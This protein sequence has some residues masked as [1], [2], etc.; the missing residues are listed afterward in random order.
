MIGEILLGILALAGSV[1]AY[2]RAREKNRQELQMLRTEHQ[3]ALEKQ[4][5][6]T[7]LAIKHAQAEHEAWVR[8]KM[9]EADKERQ[10]QDKII[11]QLQNDNALHVEFRAAAE[12]KAEERKKENQRLL[13]R[14]DH[15]QK[16]LIEAQKE[17][18]QMP[19]LRQLV[20]QMTGRVDSLEAQVEHERKR[21]SALI[22]ENRVVK[23]E[24]QS[25]RERVNQLEREIAE[26]R[27]ALARQAEGLREREA[28]Y[29]LADGEATNA[30]E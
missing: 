13:E 11:L 20:E 29:P 22:D 24:N 28:A 17:A 2:L 6:D 19:V 14:C 10:Q 7:E 30:A 27:D 23:L 26:L 12:V 8:A 3:Q 21:N 9:D 25:L 4:R 16:Q 1:L 15:L 5:S 18:A